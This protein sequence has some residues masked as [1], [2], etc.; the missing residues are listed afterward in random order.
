VNGTP[1]LGRNASHHQIAEPTNLSHVTAQTQDRPKYGKDRDTYQRVVQEEAQMFDRSLKEFGQLELTQDTVRAMKDEWSRLL[2]QFN[3][4]KL[5][6]PDIHSEFPKDKYDLYVLIIT[7]Q[8]SKC[9]ESFD[10]QS[11]LEM[12][13]E[14][15][16]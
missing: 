5:I 8:R 15:P 11:C 10:M 4:F 12:L 9:R 1:K 16:L 7:L 13:F 2:P 6:F 14:S 3:R